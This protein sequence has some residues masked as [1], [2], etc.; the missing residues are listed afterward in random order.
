MFRPHKHSIASYKRDKSEYKEMIKMKKSKYALERGN[1]LSE[2]AQDKN[3]KVF[4][5]FL[6]VDRKVPDS[7]IKL[8][9]WFE[10]FSSILNPQQ[11]NDY[12]SVNF[13]HESEFH[14]KKNT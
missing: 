12:E 4:W 1:R 11:I 14:E 13:E 3:P 8:D 6:K 2:A 9:D 10:H 7:K 5:N